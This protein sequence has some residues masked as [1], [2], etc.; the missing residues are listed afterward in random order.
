MVNRLEGEIRHFLNGKLVGADEFQ[1]GTYGDISLG[2]WYLGGIPGLND[3]NGSID[4]AR[5][6][7]SALAEEDIAAI[8]NGGAGDRGVGGNLAAPH[9]TQDNPITISLSFSKVGSGV[10]VSGL[11]EAD[12]IAA[13]TGGTLL[14]GSFSSIDGN[15]T[16]TFEIIPDANALE[17]KL[18]L[19]AGSG[20]YGGTEGTLAVNRTIGIVPNVLSKSE[21][22]N[23]W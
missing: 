17:V 13:L 4:D 5:I 1:E 16:F 22:T 11:E 3:F 23:W 12:I 7:S 14:P 8:Y 10:V 6:Y 9:I 18:A 15:Q 20:V 2:D 19:P 21:I